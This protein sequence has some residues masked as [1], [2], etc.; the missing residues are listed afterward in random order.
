MIVTCRGT[1]YSLIFNLQQCCVIHVL[2]FTLLKLLTYQSLPLIFFLFPYF[3]FW[4]LYFWKVRM[5]IHLG[6]FSSTFPLGFSLLCISPFL[7]WKGLLFVWQTVWLWGFLFH[8]SHD[9]HFLFWISCSFSCTC[10]VDNIVWKVRFKLIMTA[11][12]K[13]TVFK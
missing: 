2:K 3:L 8:L 7:Y 12:G 13:R 6:Q 10:L 11:K 4:S 9:S 1:E 5:A